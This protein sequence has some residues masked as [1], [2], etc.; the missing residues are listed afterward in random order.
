MKYETKKKGGVKKSVGRKSKD[1]TK[2][3]EDAL[4]RHSEHHSK[5]HISEMRRL[6]KGGKTFTES[7]KIAM[8]KIGK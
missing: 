6:M 2:R 8:K 7:H 4:K 5:K 1:L 3:Q